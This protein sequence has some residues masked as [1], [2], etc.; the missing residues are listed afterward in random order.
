MK[1]LFLTILLIC[2]AG[3]EDD[4]RNTFDNT[5]D[6]G[7]DAGNFQTDKPIQGEAETEETETQKEISEPKEKDTG[8][9]ISELATETGE[10]D[11]QSGPGTETETETDTETETEEIAESC[12]LVLDLF[13]ECTG[14]GP[15]YEDMKDSCEWGMHD[16]SACMLNC[17]NV[18]DCP[19][20]LSCEERC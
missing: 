16:W 1:R 18:S 15:R 10:A 17:K 8:S 7:S 20:F 5:D 4:N 14:N 11:T 2:F 13:L 9:G 6:S 3:C 12:G 19:E